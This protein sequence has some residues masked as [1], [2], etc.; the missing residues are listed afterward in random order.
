MAIYMG[1]YGLTAYGIGWLQAG[2]HF[3]LGSI[4]LCLLVPAAALS[5]AAS[6]ASRISPQAEPNPVGKVEPPLDKRAFFGFPIPI[7]KKDLCAKINSPSTRKISSR[8][9]KN[10]FTPTKTFLSASSSPT[11]SDALNKVQI[12]A[13]DDAAAD[14]EISI[15]IDKKAKTLTI[16]DTGIGM[17]EEEV[18]K[19]IAQIAFS[20]L[21]SLSQNI[22]PNGERSDHRPFWPRL[23]LRLHGRL[24]S[25]DRHALLSPR[26]RARFLELRW[27][28]LLFDRRGQAGVLAAPKSPSI[29]DE[30]K[31]RIPRRRRKCESS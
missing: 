10:G 30:R 25:G 1:G 20:A 24:Q 12:L 23:L 19:Y 16:S 29:I 17:T 26:C 7:T 3:S 31:P 2:F 22:S 21:K 5:L 8:S 28:L 18:E 6:F 14:F 15:T 27:R 9:S 13:Q 4:F 11:P